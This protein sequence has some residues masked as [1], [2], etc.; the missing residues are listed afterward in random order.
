MAGVRGQG[1]SV[2]WGAQYSVLDWGSCGM[3]AGAC[4]VWMVGGV[5]EVGRVL[6]IDHRC[7]TGLRYAGGLQG[8]LERGIAGSRLLVSWWQCVG[9]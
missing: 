1:V 2:L 5:V 8:K 4:G 7:P 3:S 9:A 6:I